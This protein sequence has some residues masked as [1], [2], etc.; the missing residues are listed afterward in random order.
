MRAIPHDRDRS[1]N[2]AGVSSRTGRDGVET[3]RKLGQ[4]G[5]QVRRFFDHTW[6][7]GEQID[8]TTVI[9]IRI[10]PGLM[11]EHQQIEKFC[12]TAS[13]RVFSYDLAIQTRYLKVMRKCIVKSRRASLSTMHQLDPLKRRV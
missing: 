2:F 7:L 10:K 6:T 11:L 1:M 4:H 12:A 9:N 13:R 5:Y 3:R 8:K